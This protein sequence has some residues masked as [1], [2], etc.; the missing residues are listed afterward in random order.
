MHDFSPILHTFLR[1]LQKASVLLP[2]ETRQQV[3]KNAS[4]IPH[5]AHF[6]GKSE[7][8]AF[9]I[10][11]DL[12]SLGLARFWQKFK[13]W[14]RS[15]C[16]QQCVASLHRLLRGFCTEQTNCSRCVWAV[17]RH[18]S[19]AQQCFDDW[20]SQ[21]L[22][23][24]FQFRRGLQRASPRKDCDLFP[25]MQDL[26]CLIQVIA[27]GQH[28]AT[29][30]GMRGVVGDIPFGTLSALDFH[31]LKVH[32]KSQ[33]ADRTI[34]EC[35][36]HRQ[37]CNVLHVGG[38]HDPLIERG[39]IH[40]EAVEPYILLGKRSDQIMKLQAR[41][42]QHGLAVHLC[43]VYTIENMNA[44]GTRRCQANAQP[45]CKFGIRTGHECRRLF[46][47]HLNETNPI[48]TRPQRFHQAIDSI[49]RQTEN[50]VYTPVN[51]CFNQNISSG[52]RLAPSQQ[53]LRTSHNS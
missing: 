19:S 40:V 7:T 45:S 52:H 21:Y 39:D 53:K 18:R 29:S 27:V 46:V 50:D 24:L 15:S 13:I 17:I 10:K 23:N 12:H 42:C 48:L 33:M 11:L 35:R 43:I 14:K 16:H 4:A 5:Q 51:Q 28:G 36:A 41:D 25:F 2:L 38:T 9:G 1:F 49:S 22:G 37:V 31:F 44:S 3:A 32:G 30:F 20:S 26:C 47:S 6:D 34:S 8:D